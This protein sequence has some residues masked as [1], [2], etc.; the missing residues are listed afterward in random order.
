ML[1]N[2]EHLIDACGRAGRGA[3]ARLPRRCASWPPAASR[4]AS[5][6][7]RLARAV[8]GRARSAGPTRRRTLAAGRGGAAVRRA[9]AAAQ[10]RLRPDGE[11]TPR[12][13][14]DLCRRLDGIPLALELA[15]ARVAAARGRAD[16]RAAGRQLRAAHRRA[17][18]TACRAS[19]RC[20]RRSTG[21]TTCSTSRSGSSSAG[22]RSSPAAGRWKRPRRCAAA[23]ASR[24]TR[25]STCWR[26]LVD[27]SLVQVE[28]AGGERRATGCWRRCA[29][30][31]WSGCASGDEAAPRGRHARCLAL[32]EAGKADCGGPNQARGWRRLEREHDN[33][34]AA[35]G[36]CDKAGD[37]PTA[38]AAGRRPVGVLDRARR[39]GGGPLAGAGDRPGAGGGA[40]GGA[41]GRCRAPGLARRSRATMRRRGPPG[42]GGRDR[43]GLGARATWSG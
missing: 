28:G 30:M 20:G 8:A 42:G 37:R 31:R 11:R 22:W 35:L 12:P 39:A 24:R 43:R 32:A 38:S 4:C 16:R 21:A 1:D 13:W 19:R 18:A 9:G 5:R 29:S 7:G 33:L 27:K 6:R 14:R 15:A 41:G 17:A 3:A 2:C 34:R 10:P 25:C 26:R 36:W 40:D 23:T